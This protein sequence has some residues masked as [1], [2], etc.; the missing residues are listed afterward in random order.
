MA[1][2]RR[3]TDV[4]GVIPG[5]T[6][7]LDPHEEAYDILAADGITVLAT[8]VVGVWRGATA[9]GEHLAFALEC[10]AVSAADGTPLAL[11]GTPVK[12]HTITHSVPMSA[13][14][15]GQLTVAQVAQFVRQRAADVLVAKKQALQAV[16]ALAGKDIA[17]HPT[18]GGFGDSNLSGVP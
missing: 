17:T 3:R 16:A 4:N 10:R 18:R 6:V 9:D 15:E 12:T 7:T 1:T 11:N 14:T 13:I 2:A 5:W 8:L